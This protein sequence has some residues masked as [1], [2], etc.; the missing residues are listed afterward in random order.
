MRVSGVAR[1]A[2]WLEASYL[3]QNGTFTF[4]TFGGEQNATGIETTTD[5]AAPVA[6]ITRD[7]ADPTSATTVAFSADFS[8][9]VTNVSAA[10]FSLA[11][12]GT[13]TANATVVVD[14]EGDGDASTYTV[15]VDTIA[16]HGT[17]GLDIAGGN[18]IT[19]L[20]TNVANTTPTTDQ[21]YTINNAP[22][23]TSNGG[24]ATAAINAAENQTA[25]TTVTV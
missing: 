8:E 4:T 13:V 24:A 9:D 3:S 2:D 10:D 15:T 5:K 22:V 1:S 20:V 21:A 25:V 19:D 23:I 14:D 12:T 11:L 18:D 17:L 16:G 7:D 6:T